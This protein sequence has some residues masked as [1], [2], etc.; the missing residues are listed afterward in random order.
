MWH[1]ITEKETFQI[2][3]ARHLGKYMHFTFRNSNVTTGMWSRLKMMNCT[4]QDI[5][6]LKEGRII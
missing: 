4:G 6:E 3:I 2:K 1:A 5:R